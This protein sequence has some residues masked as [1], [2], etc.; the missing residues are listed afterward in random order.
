M[1]DRYSRPVMTRIWDINNRFEKWLMVEILVCEA[2]ANN[3]NIPQEAVENIKKKA[4]FDIGK[5]EEIEK[6]TRHDV[7]AFLTNVAEY[8]GEDSRYIHMGLTSSDILDTSLSIQMREA[9]D[10]ILK[11]L[12][13]LSETLKKRALKFK[14]T[15]MIGRSHGIH[16]EPITFG[17]KLALWYQEVERDIIRMERAKEIIGYGKISGAVGTFGNIDPFVEEYVCKNSGLKVEPISSQIIQRDRHAE[18][19]CTLA[20]IGSSIDKFATEIRHLQRTEVMEVEEFFSEGQK[21]SSSMPHKRNPI[22]SE[23]LSGLARILRAN[24]IAGLEDIPLWHERDISHSSVERIIIPDST[25]LIDY[26]LNKMTWIIDTLIIYPENMRKNLEKTKGLIFSQRILIELVK[27]GLLREEAYLMVQR[28]ATK[29][30][31]GEGDFKE[32]ILQDRD[33]MGYLT[34][35]T[36]EESFDLN[37]HLKNVDTIFKRVFG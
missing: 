21:G 31:N 35:Q 12:E 16:A 6:R 10:I 2:L 34:T 4:R 30:L 28:N 29:V 9:S 8:V 26:M 5:I 18:F 37:Y 27:G 36:V 23:Q 32:L 20:I 15:V 33:I 1:I 13:R 24:S 14:N 7:V 19:L 3:G 11:D 25:I 22:A 17:L